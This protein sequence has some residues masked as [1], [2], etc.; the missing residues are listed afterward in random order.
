M[1]ITKYKIA[2]YLLFQANSETLLSTK[3]VK[4]CSKYHNISTECNVASDYQN[5]L[6]CVSRI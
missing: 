5:C 3:S 2:I 4:Y 6:C 1:K